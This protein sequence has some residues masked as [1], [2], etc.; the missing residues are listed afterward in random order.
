MTLHCQLSCRLCLGDANRTPPNDNVGGPLTTV[1]PAVHTT[2]SDQTTECHHTVCGRADWCA[3]QPS[4]DLPTAVHE[5]RCCSD[6]SI[7]GWS[8]RADT[9]PWTES[10]NFDS[11][12]TACIH[13]STFDEADDFC[14]GV[15]AR[16]CTSAEA[17]SDCLRGTGCGHDSDLIWTS[18]AGRTSAVAPQAAMDFGGASSN[19]ETTS[20][21]EPTTVVQINRLAG[22]GNELAASSS[23][24]STAADSSTSAGAVAGAVIGTLALVVLIAAVFE[25]QRQRRAGLVARGQAQTVTQTARETPTGLPNPTQGLAVSAAAVDGTFTVVNTEASLRLVSVRRGNPAFRNSVIAASSTDGGL[26]I[27]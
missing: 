13:A 16:L 1:Q 17:E 10:N 6:T 14:T 11:E 8:H 2:S 19:A 21:V 18:D 27:A 25:H 12:N 5:V 22:A 4:C 3:E 24:A 20:T 23:S 7:A 26:T 9:C 15:G